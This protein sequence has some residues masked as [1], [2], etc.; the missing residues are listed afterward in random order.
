MLGLIIKRLF[1]FQHFQKGDAPGGKQK[2]GSPDYKNGGREKHSQSL[3]RRNNGN[4]HIVPGSCHSQPQQNQQPFCLRLFFSL[5]AARHKLNRV[6]QADS[7][8]I[9]QQHYQENRSEQHRC[10]QRPV[11]G[12]LIS[13][14]KLHNQNPQ[15]QQKKQL[16]KYHARD[17]PDDQ[18]DSGNEERFQ[19]HDFSDMAFRH[20]QNVVKGQF[21]FPLFN[22]KAVCIEQKNSGKNTYHPHSELQQAP[23]SRTPEHLRYI[24]I[25]NNRG[26]NIEDHNADDT[27]QHIRHIAFSVFL[28]IVQRQAS[29]K[30]FTH[31]FH[32][33]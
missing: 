25:V 33:L 26:H 28:H 22:Q 13:H 6:C 17:Q 19:Q 18:R 5:A 16:S 7:S 2:I 29:V 3:N 10:Q 23:Q 24:R 20:A 1:L 32:L 14:G 11:R 8:Q 31:G 9:A 4:R 21:F 15:Q 12:N 30:G 27:G